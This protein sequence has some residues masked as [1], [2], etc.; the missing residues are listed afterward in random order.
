[1]II[2]P[3]FNDYLSSYVAAVGVLSAYIHAQKT[4]K[5]QEVDVAQFE[6]CAKLLADT[7]T[8]YSE[9]GQVKRR[10]GSDSPAFQPYGL[11]PTKMV[12]TLSLVPLALEY[13]RELL[14]PLA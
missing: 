4:G 12:N 7:V 11:L 1:M 6:A 10:S 2:K 8:T 3:W 9:T 13:T 14:M 5:G